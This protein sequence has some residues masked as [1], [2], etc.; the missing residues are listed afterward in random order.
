MNIG[1]KISFRRKKMGLTQE[2]LSKGICSITYLSKLENNR[3]EANIEILDLLSKRLQTPL[4]ELT[5]DDQTEVME[6]LRGIY[7]RVIKRELVDVQTPLNDL[8]SLKEAYNPF[9][10]TAFYIVWFEFHIAKQDRTTAS[11]IKKELLTREHYLTD[12]TR[13]WLYKSLGYFEYT[14]GNLEKSAQHFYQAQKLAHQNSYFEAHIEYLLGLVNTRLMII[15]KSIFHTE[16]A[17]ELYTQELDLKKIIQ[18]QLLLAVNYCKIDYYDTAKKIYTKLIEQS[19]QQPINNPFLGKVYHNLGYLFLKTNDFEQAISEF[20]KA[21]SYKEETTEQLSTLY[22]LSY[23]NKQQGSTEKALTLCDKIMTLSLD[24]DPHFSYKAYILKVSIIQPDLQEATF[25][26]RFENEI[27]PFFLQRDPN[28]AGECYRILGQ[29][30]YDQQKYKKSARFYKKA[31]E[32]YFGTK[33]KEI[34]L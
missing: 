16:K 11:E 15:S 23:C 9:V 31:H 20:K 19:N 7:K 25:I 4:L 13:F 12:E 34:L 22:L 27:I 21:L 5:S 30:Y 14:F 29:I 24:R 6:K 28:I 10:S 3:I 33:Q 17:I 26:D 2:K 8:K 18:C 32:L 1:G